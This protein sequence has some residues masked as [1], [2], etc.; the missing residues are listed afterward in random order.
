MLKNQDPPMQPRPYVNCGQM[1]EP[2]PPYGNEWLL[3][4]F[5]LYECGVAVVGPAPMS[6]LGHPITIEAVREASLKDLHQEW[7]PLLKDSTPLTDS[8]LQAY[9]ILTLCRILHRS[10]NDGVASKKVATAWVKNTYGI[11]WRDLIEKA[12]LWQHG[13]M[14]NETSEILKFI[15]FTLQEVQ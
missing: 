15:Q 2:D 1:W 9:V 7:E 14:L 5:V 4:L 6:I 12:E 13:Q 8:H 11:A 3:N 10:K